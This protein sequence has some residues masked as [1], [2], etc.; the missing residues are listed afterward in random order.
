MAVS[1]T[2]VD[3]SD[4]YLAGDRR[5]ALSEGR[6]LNDRVRGTAL[7]ADVSGFTP[8]TEALAT[9]LGPQRGAE[10]L[11]AHLNRVFHA[12]IDDVDRYG[13][14]VIYFG[15]DAITCWL[16]GDDGRRGAAC[17]LAIQRTMSSVGTIR[18]P[19]G[20]EVVLAIKVAVAVGDARR[21]VV[22]DPSIQL[23]DVLAG[24]LIDE[25]ADAEHLAEKG[26]VVLARSA[27]DSL[28]DQVVI[29]EHR[30]GEHAADVGVL[31]GLRIEVDVLQALP[32]LPALGEALVRPWILPAVYERLV[33]GRGEFLAEL[34]AAY[35]VF[36][37]FGG[38]DYD[39]D[40]DAIAQL[41]HFVRRVQQVLSESGGNL[42]HVI[43]GD[44]GAYL[45]AVFGTPHAHEDDASRAATAAIEL[46]TLDRETAAA[47]DLQIGI[48]HGRVRSGTYG[49]PMRRT[50]TCLGDAVNLSARLMSAAPSGHAYISEEAHRALSDRFECQLVGDLTVKGKAEPVRVLSI[51]GLRRG[52]TKR[53]IRYPL[54]MVGR[55]VEL[56]VFAQA[57]DD[58]LGGAGRVVG[59]S[60]EAG[61]GKSRL[62]RGAELRSHHQ[63]SR[64]A[65]RVA[66]PARG[67]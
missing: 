62:G 24:R 34:R 17:G 47:T 52:T 57:L 64:V 4:A 44:K 26:D 29:G 49:H 55:D 20:T 40:P 22:G 41:D 66:N 11:T 5:R 60:A 23:I 45:C 58:V 27:L 21:F 31:A 36:V 3:R 51:V 56:G 6:Q 16:D 65:R 59:I 42:L 39:H 32:P 61:R 13:G 18:T 67:R 28:G 50:F 1:D 15:G 46:L 38:I 10:E 54:P 7:F 14:E 53:E 25:L 2:D 43:L 30:M 19:A 8:L 48:T 9:E 63:L 12:V 37:R 33:T 35:P